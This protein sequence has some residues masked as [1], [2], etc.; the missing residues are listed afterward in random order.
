ME[1][2]LRF[3]ELV[4]SQGEAIPL[5]LASALIAQ[6]ADAAVR[7]DAILA[8]LDVLAETCP[9]YTLDSLLPH[10]F[11]H[12]R[13]G[14][15]HDDYY[16]PRNSLID[17]VLERRCG[18]PITLAVVGLEVGRRIGVPMAGVGMPGHFL[19]QDKVDRTVFIDPFHGG[20]LLREAD[21]QQLFHH[22][23]GGGSTWSTELL[24]PV[25]NLSI[26]TRM[27]NNLRVVYTRRQDLGALRWVM[28]LRACLPSPYGDEPGEFARSMA[29]LN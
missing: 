13:F 22:V 11:G 15:D 27:L 29:P 9:G 3:A 21:C 24:A 18:I 26:V 4:E 1:P 23:T 25:G 14:P 20:R 6:C 17:R 2:T 16:D 7:P 28:A 10:L 5:D 12:G 19:L 8:Q